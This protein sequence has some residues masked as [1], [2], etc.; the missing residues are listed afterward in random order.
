MGPISNLPQYRRICEY[1]NTAKQEGATLVTGGVDETLKGWFI[2]PTVFTNVTPQMRVVKEEI[3]GPVLCVL[4]FDTEEE[5]IALA[6]DTEYGLAGSVWTQNIQRAHRVSDKLRAGTV[7]VNS[8][9]A[10]SPSVPFG[11]FGASGLGRENGMESILDFMETKA[12]WIELSGA[13]R[14]PFRMA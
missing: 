12:V 1:L 4:P 8:Y 11:G 10:V 2:K 9:R 5:A 14:D 13:T 7:W 3:F 6:N